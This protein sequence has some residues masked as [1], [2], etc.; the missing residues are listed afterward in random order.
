MHRCTNEK[1]KR[2]QK[3]TALVPLRSE[4][5]GEGE[6]ASRRDTGNINAYRL[7]ISLFQSRI[8]LSI[9]QPAPLRANKNADRLPINLYKYAQ[10]RRGLVPRGV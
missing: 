3:K 1:S 2:A 9:Y 7:P 6:F 10:I 4:V 8:K 5:Q